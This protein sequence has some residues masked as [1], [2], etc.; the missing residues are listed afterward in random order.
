MENKARTST[1][2]CSNVGGSSPACVSPSEAAELGSFAAISQRDFCPRFLSAGYK[3]EHEHED[4][5]ENDW[6]DGRGPE[7]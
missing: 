2:K 3:T 5:Y 6:G 4:Y 7:R 1:T